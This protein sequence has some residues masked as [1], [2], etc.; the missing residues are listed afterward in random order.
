MMSVGPPSSE[1]PQDVEGLLAKLEEEGKPLKIVSS[2]HRG[3]EGG[4]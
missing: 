4:S 1:E 3:A 2:A